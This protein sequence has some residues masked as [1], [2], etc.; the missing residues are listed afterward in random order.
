MA[1]EKLSIIVDAVDHASKTL[2][3]IGR[4]MKHVGKMAGVA[5]AAGVAALTAELVLAT[6]AANEQE[7]ADAQLAAA[8]KATAG[9]SGQTMESLKSMASALQGTTTFGD[10]AIE[11][12]QALL[13][14]F[15]QIGGDTFPE[16]TRA[17]LDMS[18]AMGTDLK[19]SAIQIG[20]A[21]NDPIK[22]L[23]ALSRVGVTFSESQKGVIES[24]VATGDTAAAQKIILEEL[25]SEFGGSAQ[26]AADT[27]SGAMKQD[28]NAFGDLQEEIGNVFVKSAM[29]RD[30]LKNL[31]PVLQSASEWVKNNRDKIRTWVID[32]INLAIDATA[33]LAQTM[34]DAWVGIKTSA[35]AIIG[36]MLGMGIALSKLF[37]GTNSI[38][39]LRVLQRE[40]A[41]NTAEMKRSGE[42]ASSVISNMH[43]TVSRA[44]N[45]GNGLSAELEIV[46]D[47]YQA[48]ADAADAASGAADENAKRVKRAQDIWTNLVK[49]ELLPLHVDM[50]HLDEDID[51]AVEQMQNKL[52]LKLLIDNEEKR[53]QDIENAANGII[54]ATQSVGAAVS[55][56]VEVVAKIFDETVPDWVLG[57]ISMVADFL[58]T[59][60]TK[61]M[62]KAI[63]SFVKGFVLAL[64]NVGTLIAV[65][66]DDMDDIVVG[67]V[68]GVAG[69]VMGIIVNIPNIII[70]LFR[71]VNDIFGRIGNELDKMLHD[72]FVAAVKFFQERFTS[73]IKAALSSV[74]NFF[75]DLLNPFIKV[76]NKLPGVDI[77]LIK[78]VDYRA[79]GGDVI[80]GRPYIV[81]ER[82]AELIVPDRSGVVHPAGSFGRG[83]GGNATINI[84]VMAAD[85]PNETAARVRAALQTLIDSR[86]LRFDPIRGVA[87]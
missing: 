79:D 9:V 19:S 56:V 5:A 30:I 41:D 33:A 36:T 70:G 68:K 27:F 35:G 4:T 54:A 75:I 25:N 14:T 18:T 60:T 69:L 10:E 3:K 58:S 8:L 26:A 49:T 45:G 59:A 46:S 51:D 1:S 76:I 34:V 31:K 86:Q 42:A 63:K 39:Q 81:G 66:A 52:H 20:K 87:I 67:F 11:K 43:T 47:K 50:T 7:L 17:M 13:L 64:E 55:A 48:V 6:K 80:A 37:G 78:H 44:I 12:G 24:L 29:F 84:T 2:D 16:A 83:V 85:N 73:G 57:A 74:V 32:G 21:L 40:L 38:Q 61:S 71:A 62:D 77:G 65:I 72:V 15:K 23:S 28:M 82:G 53:A 22:G